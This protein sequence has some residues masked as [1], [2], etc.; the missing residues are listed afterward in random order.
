MYMG[1]RSF[2]RNDV[3]EGAVMVENIILLI[4][5]VPF[6]LLANILTILWIFD[7]KTEQIKDIIK[8]SLIEAYIENST[9][10]Q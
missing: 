5:V 1:R 2:E 9:R 7:F 10:G 8:D 3:N 6:I 4:G